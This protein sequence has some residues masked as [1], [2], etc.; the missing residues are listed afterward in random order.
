MKRN[1]IICNTKGACSTVSGKLIT[2]HIT[3]PKFWHSLMLLISMLVVFASCKPANE[4]TITGKVANPVGQTVEIYYFKNLVGSEM[5]NIEVPLDV[6]HGFTATLP[7]SEG[8]FVYI[9]LSRRNIMLYLQPGAEIAITLDEANPDSLP[10]V[11]GEGA[12]ESQFLVSYA[13]NVGR[14]HSRAVLLNN[15]GN[16]TPEQ[17]LATA[18]QG[19]TEKKAYLE[20]HE[21]FAEFDPNFV[22][23]MKANIL[24]EKYNLLLEYPMAF[25]HFNPGAESPQLPSEFYAFLENDNLFD[26]KFVRSRTYLR[27]MQLYLNRKMEEAGPANPE[28]SYFDG[29]FNL[30]ENLLP[31]LSRDV[32]LGE[33]TLM[34]LSHMEWESAQALYNRFLAIATNQSVIDVVNVEHQK[35]MA[36]APGQPAPAFTLTDIN[37]QTVSLSDFAGK[38]VYL[39]FWASWCG[40]CMREVPYAKELK[41]RMENQPDLVFLYISVDVDEAA[42]RSTVEQHQIQGVHLNVPGFEHEVPQAYNLQGVPTF[43]LIGRDGTIISNSPPRPSNPA[44]DQVLLDALAL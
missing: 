9:R 17:F 32:I 10:V 23:L 13:M 2:K 12:L 20:N 31:G 24:Y 21:Y 28:V 29:M 27:F 16:L 40:P 5:E 39:D 38:V 36:L 4:V 44:I 14:T 34:A 11:T 1:S 43:F 7:L 3:V 22:A 25:A 19:Y 42:W 33:L 18:T 6:N 41:K 35:V 15:V 8:Q 30:A 37:G 26:D